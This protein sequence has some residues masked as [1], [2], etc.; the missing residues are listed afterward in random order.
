MQITI[1]VNDTIVEHL[2]AFA[3]NTSGHTP[4]TLAAVLLEDSVLSAVE[5]PELLG[6]NE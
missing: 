5:D 6:N 3:N 2:K 1:T 4:E